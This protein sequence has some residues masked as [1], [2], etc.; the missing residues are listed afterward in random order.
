MNTPAEL[1]NSLYKICSQ[2]AELGTIYKSTRPTD[3]KAEECVIRIVSGGMAK[4]V[5]LF[6]ASV[7]LFYPAIEVNGTISIDTAKSAVKE[8]LLFAVSDKLRQEMKDCTA[9]IDTR[10]INTELFPYNTPQCFSTLKISFKN[11]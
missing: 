5:H 6:T 11:T 2:V 3:S 4:H 9:L 7:V 1:L 8:S 10:I